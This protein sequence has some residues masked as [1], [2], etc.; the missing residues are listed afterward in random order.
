M[1]L[2]RDEHCPPHVHA[3][4]GQWDARFKFSF[5]DNSVSLWDV[6]PLRN[7]PTADVLEG[8]RLTLKEKSNL[9]LARE[10][11][12]EM[13]NNVCLINQRWDSKAKEVVS[14]KHSRTGA[15]VIKAARFDASAY[16]TVLTLSGQTSPVEIKL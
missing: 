14:G 12:W 3:G 13:L 10:K 6:T 15:I 4:N 5:S 1:I 9:R 7:K 2:T 16:K 11:W 8:L